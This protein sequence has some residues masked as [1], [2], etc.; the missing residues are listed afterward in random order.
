MELGPLARLLIWLLSHCPSMSSHQHKTTHNSQTHIPVVSALDPDLISEELKDP[1]LR[2]YY[3]DF[4]EACHTM[5]AS[6]YKR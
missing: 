1:Y 6:R 3:V 5:P 2:A 4:L